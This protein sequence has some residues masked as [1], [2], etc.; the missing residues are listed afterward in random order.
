MKTEEKHLS[1]PRP[2]KT[3][4]NKLI[5]LT[6]RNLSLSQILLDYRRFNRSSC[7]K[8]VNLYSKTKLQGADD[9]LGQ[10]L[11]KHSKQ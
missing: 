3:F 5:R 6:A 1:L 11:W 4:K 7:T 8:S 10:T 2:F 9:K